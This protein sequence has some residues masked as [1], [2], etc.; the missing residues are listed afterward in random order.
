[1]Y[2]VYPS[3]I[4]GTVR[5]PA[6]KSETHREYV[7]SA[8]AH[9][10]SVIRN[11]LV[12][13]D[14]E[15]T[16][17]GIA[18]LGAN[19]VR[20]GSDVIITGGF[21]HAADDVID[22]GN[23]GTTVRFLT[24]V[25]SRICGTTRFTGDKSLMKRP[26]QPLLDALSASCGAEFSFEDGILSVTG[27][28][29]EAVCAEIRGDI[30]SQFIS[31]LLIAGISVKLTSP[32]VS[33][34]YVDM[35]IHTLEMRDVHIEKTLEGFFV[36]S[37]RN[38]LLPRTAEISGD[39]SSAAFL[40][41]AGA[42]SGQVT[43]TGLD[44]DSIQGDKRIVSLLQKFGADISF[45]DGITVSKSNLKACDADLSDTPDLFPA[46]AVIAAAASG[47]SRLYGV[48]HLIYKESNRLSTMSAIL[49]EMSASVEVSSGCVM[50]T[51]GKLHGASVSAESDHRLFMAAAV[52]GLCAEGTVSISDGDN[53]FAVSYPAFVQD[54][55]L[56]G[57]DIR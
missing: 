15:A 36:D 4:F 18:A 8:L 39:W 26:M 9:G 10:T 11:P 40:F 32:L 34:S 16:L 57:G 31:S 33:S 54:I 28:S 51:G 43:V 7:L 42:L 14:T 19:V 50:I 49:S 44:V 27:S 13:A 25:A 21:L 6:S 5:A 55:R 22:C 23:S 2:T 38:V 20:N 24:G 35:T 30:S 46:L 45:G 37:K 56:L 41:A 12:S 52:A 29:R 48:S 47:T 53:V 1:M 3:K 17:C